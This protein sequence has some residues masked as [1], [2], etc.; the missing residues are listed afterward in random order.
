MD[1]LYRLPA[2]LM[3]GG[4]SKGLFIRADSLPEDTEQWEA[5]L[6]R[7]LGSPDPYGLQMDGLG[8]GLASSSKVMILSPS[9]RDD[10]DI[11]CLFGHASIAD[12]RIDWSG[13]CG[14][15]SAAAPLFAMLEN[16]AR[17]ADG[18]A[19][20]AIWQANVGKRILAE[21]EVFDGQPVWQGDFFIDGVSFPGAPIRLRFLDPCGV[22]SGELFPSGRLMDELK[23]PDG[24]HIEAT[25]VDAGNPTVFVRARDFGLSGREPAGPM[26]LATLRRLELARAT[27]AVAMGLAEDIFAAERERPAFPRISFLSAAADAECQLNARLLSMDRV[28]H[29]YSGTGA[30][31]LACACAVDGTLPA[32]LAGGAVRGMPLTFSHA[33]GKQTLEA[34][35]GRA[36]LGWSVSEVVMTRTARPLMR[37]EVYIPPA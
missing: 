22:S 11:D 14:N 37:G 36:E 19:T 1:A 31:A 16:M 28:H 34:V 33:S 7:A 25:L 13:N 29:A 17:P 23:L 8:T 18:V 24:S 21:L 10:C 27:A 35:L 3:R 5:M 2:M 26:P 4:T 6:L 30:I 9:R 12:A 32:E 15:L 20:I